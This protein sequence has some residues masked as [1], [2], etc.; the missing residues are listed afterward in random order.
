MKLLLYTIIE[1][2]CSIQPSNLRENKSYFVVNVR[3]RIFFLFKDHLW[4]KCW[5]NKEP[6]TF[7]FSP[8]IRKFVTTTTVYWFTRI[9]Q[10][11]I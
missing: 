2:S 1:W 10:H 7:S 3:N 6:K 11:Q 9:F 4:V 8:L 5:P